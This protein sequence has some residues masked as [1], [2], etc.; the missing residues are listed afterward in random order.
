MEL[1]L[2]VPCKNRSD[3][4][5]LQGCELRR[6]NRCGAVGAEVE[7]DRGRGEA[8]GGKG[9]TARRSKAARLL[10]GV[11]AM[12]ACGVGEVLLSP[13]LLGVKE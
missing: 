2:C 1:L 12:F 9:K 7:N 3:P 6:G 5:P 8:R 4:A 10:C 13:L 11:G